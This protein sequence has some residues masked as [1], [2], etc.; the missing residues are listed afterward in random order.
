MRIA[1]VGAEGLEAEPDRA[2]ALTF[3]QGREVR[4]ALEVEHLD[5]GGQ[6]APG[7][8]HVAHERPRDRALVGGDRLGHLA[9]DEAHRA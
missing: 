9:L 2:F 4:A 7:L 1:R 5:V 3:H 6:D 8:G